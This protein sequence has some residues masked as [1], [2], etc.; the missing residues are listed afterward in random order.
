MGVVVKEGIKG[1]VVSYIGAG[2]GAITTLFIY[3]YFLSPEEVGLMRLL[4]DV[5]TMFSFFALLGAQSVMVKFF[6]YFQQR[7]LE[8]TFI[9][10]CFVVPLLGFVAVSGVVCFFSKPIINAFEGNSQL[11][12][13]S[14]YH[15][16]P[17]ALAMVVLA[18]FETLSTI[19]RR[20]FAS[21]FIRDILIRILTI[22]LIFLYFYH[23][24]SITALAAGLA[25]VYGIA[26][27]ANGIYYHH[28]GAFSL[29]YPSGKILSRKLTWNMSKFGGNTILAGLGSMLIGKI[30]VI[31]ISSKI[32][33]TNTG[34]Y[35]IA[36]FIATMI[37]IP[38]RSINSLVV[39][40]VSA[41]LNSGNMHKVAELYKKVTLNQ[42]LISGTLLL[43]I[44]INIDNFFAIMPNGDIYDAGKYVVLFI[45]LGKFVDLATGINSTIIGYSKYYFL[46][47]FCTILLG[48]L[49]IVSNLIL[50]PRLGITG[51]A[52]A[53]LASLFIYNSIMVVLVQVLL[54]VQP[55]TWKCL[56]VAATLTAAFGISLLLP[57]MANPYIS[58][59]AQTAVVGFFVIF[60][61]LAFR[62]SDE[63]VEATKMVM[64]RVK[65]VIRRR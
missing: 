34:I 55:F 16:L 60:A 21:R 14:F 24:I 59:A 63:A 43:L 38:A 25:L 5:A 29:S 4:I 50:I 36:F 47:P 8:K 18:L 65:N 7:N 23:L 6:S 13:T 48:G 9:S 42:L 41:E 3:P 51:A 19:Y 33:L 64:G 30:D 22:A 32:N 26:A 11:F 31:M 35:A 27:I 17:L 1:T 61:T 15:A 53:S 37:E 45:G 49:A 44:W 20:I 12:A 58:F 57:R 10:I 46:T 54:K 39:P 52:I 56:Q 28:T 62:L 2:I 40:Q